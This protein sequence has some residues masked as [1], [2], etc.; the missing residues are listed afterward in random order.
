M[1]TNPQAGQPA[2]LD[3]RE[4]INQT[5]TTELIQSDR[6]AD[7]FKQLFAVVHPNV[8]RIQA[9][10]FYEA[11]KYHFLKLINDSKDLSAC[12]KLSLYGNF[13]DVAVNGLSFDPSFKHLYIVPYNVNTGTFAQPIWEKRAQLQISGIGEL[14]LRMKQGQI[15]HAD[16]PVLVY[17]GD[18]FQHGMTGNTPFLNHI[19]ELPPKSANILACYIRITRNDGSVDVKVLTGADMERF[20]KFSKDADKSKAWSDGIGGMWISKCIKHAFKTY[21]K[22]RTGKFSALSSDIVDV[23]V[24]QLTTQQAPPVNMNNL[25][26]GIQDNKPT[27]EFDIPQVEQKPV[28]TVV[29]PND[30]N[31]FDM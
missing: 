5:P 9:E 3:M 29:I 18:Q 21:P 23:E 7:K 2:S 11:E 30:N 25:D 28:A 14:L 6:V 15:K 20:R 24:E 1:S 4:M 26:Y 10:A 22:L 13:M 16:N 19:A 27:N 31:E 12:T 17:E 8:N